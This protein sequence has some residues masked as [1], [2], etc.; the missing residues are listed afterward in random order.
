MR[1]HWYTFTIT[2]IYAPGIPV[3]MPGQLIIPNNEPVEE[4]L[5]VNVSVLPW[6]NIPLDVEVGGQRPGPSGGKDQ[7]IKPKPDDWDYEG[8]YGQELE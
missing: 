7:E 2:N 1:N 4:A 8:G 5:G 6:H 3:H